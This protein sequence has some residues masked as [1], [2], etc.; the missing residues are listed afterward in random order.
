MRAA[1]KAGKRRLLDLSI[2][3]FVG[4]VQAHLPKIILIGGDPVFQMR[5]E[6]RFN[7]VQH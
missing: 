1:R 3:Y 6:A 4:T 7:V 2:L 5:G